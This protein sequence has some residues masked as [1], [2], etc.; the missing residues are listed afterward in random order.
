VT[1][2]D[3]AFEGNFIAVNAAGADGR[4]Y[5]VQ[6]RNDGRSKAPAT[7]ARLH[8]VFDATDAAILADAGVAPAYGE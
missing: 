3:A 7:G 5:T 4:T 1:V 6:I 2:R 8:L